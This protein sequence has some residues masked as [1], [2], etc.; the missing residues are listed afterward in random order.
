MPPPRRRPLPILRRKRSR[1]RTSPPPAPPQNPKAA[2]IVDDSLLVCSGKMT[3]TRLGMQHKLP[4]T[5]V[6]T[7]IR[8]DSDNSS[9]KG[10][11]LSIVSQ[12][13]DHYFGMPWFL[14]E[15]E[16]LSTIEEK[17][18]D[19]TWKAMQMPFEV[20]IEHTRTR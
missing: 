10:Q 8:T 7:V 9:C 2:K 20:K 4:A 16:K 13:G 1:R 6:G 12:G 17:I 5:M 18:K 15:Q 19:F 11:F 3:V 14:D